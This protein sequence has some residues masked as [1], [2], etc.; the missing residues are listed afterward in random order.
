MTLPASCRRRQA[1][2][3]DIKLS[4]NKCGAERQGQGESYRLRKAHPLI[5]PF[6]ECIIILNNSPMAP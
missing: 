5:Q 3:S 2:V 6:H 4:K 1:C